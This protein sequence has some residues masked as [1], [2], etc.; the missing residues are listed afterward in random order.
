MNFGIIVTNMCKP[1]WRCDDQYELLMEDFLHL[2]YINPCRSWDKLPI[3]PGDLPDF[4]LPPDSMNPWKISRK[5]GK[6]TAS[7]SWTPPEHWMQR[8]ELTVESGAPDPLPGYPTR[9]RRKIHIPP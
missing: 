2:R 4:W 9:E 3:S 7:P 1:T 8:S 6:A 5:P